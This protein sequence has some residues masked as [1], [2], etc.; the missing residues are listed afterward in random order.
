[1]KEKPGN[2]QKVLIKQIRNKILQMFLL[3]ENVGT[4]I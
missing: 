2:G 3:W 1:M 4:E